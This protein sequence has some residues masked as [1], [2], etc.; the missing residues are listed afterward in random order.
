MLSQYFA[1]KEFLWDERF[2]FLLA[3]MT[4][5]AILFVTK[6]NFQKKQLSIIFS[7]YS[8]FVLHTIS[9]GQEDEVS[10]GYSQT[11]NMLN[12]GKFELNSSSGADGTSEKLFLDS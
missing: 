7:F 5:F 8:I 3:F 11:L 10:I 6:V 9:Y 4:T 12:T 2:I 1:A